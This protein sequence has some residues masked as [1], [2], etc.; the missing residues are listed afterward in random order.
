MTSLV[1]E[2]T[3]R[4]LAT[5]ASVLEIDRDILTTDLRRKPWRI[6]DVLSES[7]VFEAVMDR[8]AHPSQVV[9]P[10]LLFAVLIHRAGDELR[11]AEYVND[12]FGPRSRLPVFDVAPLHEYL[13]DGARMIFLARLLASFAVPLPLPVPEENRFDL[14]A[15]SRW[16]DS[17]PDRVG[18]M[19]HLGDLALFLAGVFPD[20]TGAAPLMPVDAERLGRGVGLSSDQILELCDSTTLASGL[21]MFEALGSRWYESAADDARQPPVVADVAHRFPAA[22]RVLN[23]LSDNYL[24][25]VTTGF[26][27]AS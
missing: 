11:D 22:R 21:S 25:Q 8:H 16:L 14:V 24:N 1:D 6:H 12:W 23:H 7:D 20:R 18:L 3:S 2:F 4:D 13:D 26:P 5:L 27:L 19:R 10:I 15:L 9:S 17:V